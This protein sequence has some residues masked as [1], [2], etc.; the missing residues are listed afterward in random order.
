MRGL[1]KKQILIGYSIAGYIDATRYKMYTSIRE[2]SL[3]Q[4]HAENFGMKN[5]KLYPIYKDENE[6]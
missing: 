3:A 5:P 6:N 4:K 2:L 1:S